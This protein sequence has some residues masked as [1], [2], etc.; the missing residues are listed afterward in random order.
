M[1]GP[2]SQVPQFL[3]AP[4]QSDKQPMNAPGAASLSMVLR[5]GMALRNAAEDVANGDPIRP[6]ATRAADRM[7]P[8]WNQWALR[9][10]LGIA[11][12]ADDDR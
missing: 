2:W 7:I 5:G 8:G 10:G 11:T 3:M 12:G 1:V 9:V 6:S 4:L